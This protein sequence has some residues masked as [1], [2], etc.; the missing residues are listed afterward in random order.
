VESVPVG[1]GT[2]P[3]TV[4]SQAFPDFLTVSPTALFWGLNTGD[5]MTAPLDGGPAT[6]F[7]SGQSNPYGFA[8]DS[9]NVYWTAANNGTVMKTPLGGGTPITLAAGQGEPLGI[10]V[11]ATSVY[12]VAQ[13]DGTV[14]KLTPK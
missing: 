13:N 8:V 12:W 14:M 7:A 11:D 10:V 3:T 2:P 4:A 6:V 1:G 5:V 9:S